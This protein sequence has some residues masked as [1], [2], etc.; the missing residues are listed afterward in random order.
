MAVKIIKPLLKLIPEFGSKTLAAETQVIFSGQ[1]FQLDIQGNV[2]SHYSIGSDVVQCAQEAAPLPHIALGKISKV[3]MKLSGKL[4]SDM[5]AATDADTGLQLP[6]KKP[7]LSQKAQAIA[8]AIAQT[9]QVKKKTISSSVAHL[10]DATEIGQKV[11]GTSNGSVYTVIA[12]GDAKVAYRIKSGSVSFRVEARTKKA[13]KACCALGLLTNNG[14]G[15]YSSPGEHQNTHFSTHME[16][17]TPLDARKII[18]A[19]TMAL[20]DT[21]DQIGVLPS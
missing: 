8:D 5:V 15:F 16:A 3:F 12:V 20:S 10:R 21:V 13:H 11:R 1:C 6:K 19:L 14:G 17:P 2:S 4:L 18:G 7:D 9:V